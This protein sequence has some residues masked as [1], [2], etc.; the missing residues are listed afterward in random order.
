MPPKLTTRC[1]YISDDVAT[2]CNIGNA[3]IPS[4]DSLISAPSLE[5]G[6]AFELVL[7]IDEGFWNPLAPKPSKTMKL[8]VAQVTIVFETSCAESSCAL[9]FI[10]DMTAGLGTGTKEAFYHFLAAFNGTNS[11]RVWSHTITKNTPARFMVAFLRS[12][13]SS[14]NDAVTD[15]ARIYAINVTNVGHRGGQGGGASQCLTCPH[16]AGG[17]TCVPCPAGNYMHEVTK[18]CVRCPEN[19]IVNVTSSRVGTESCVP[20]GQGLASKD[21][22]TCTAIGKVQLSKDKNT[23]YT[24]DFSPFVGRY[25]LSAY[26]L[27]IST[28]NIP[29]TGT[30]PVSECSRVK[31]PPTSISSWSPCSRRTSSARS[32]SI[33]LI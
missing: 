23:V 17:E 9:Y 16:T 2:G 7:S 28:D 27:I 25:G 10:E 3:W 8:P 11:K 24:Y 22:V 30:S 33:T 20:C 5:L 15:V 1:E 13:V 6:I 26:Q 21:G 14:G 32:N 4:G 19:T 18:L 31:E 12:G 29:E